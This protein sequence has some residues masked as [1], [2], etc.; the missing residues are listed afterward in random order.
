MFVTGTSFRPKVINQR[1]L[2]SFRFRLDLW[3][4]GVNLLWTKFFA[5]SKINLATNQKV[6]DV[7]L[8]AF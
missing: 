8:V 2:T 1:V 6:I 4:K 5:K 7:R 3:R